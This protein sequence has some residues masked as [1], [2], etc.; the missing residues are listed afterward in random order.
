MSLAPFFP[1]KFPYPFPA[2]TLYTLKT[3]NSYDSSF[4]DHYL[5]LLL[6]QPKGE[7]APSAQRHDNC[8]NINKEMR[9]NVNPGTN[10]FTEGCQRLHTLSNVCKNWIATDMKLLTKTMKV[11]AGCMRSYRLAR[12][13]PVT[14]EVTMQSALHLSLLPA[15]YDGIVY[16]GYDRPKWN[17]HIYSWL[18]VEQTQRLLKHLRCKVDCDG[19]IFFI[20]KPK[21]C[22]RIEL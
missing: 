4:S 9:K 13:T 11:E 16:S 7:M 8:K 3:R 12:L 20:V 22:E 18:G 2:F 15:S 19:I 21:T 5:F 14:H 1:R 6:H 17:I 10:A